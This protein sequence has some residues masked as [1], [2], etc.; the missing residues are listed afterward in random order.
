[1]PINPARIPVWDRG[2]VFG[3]SVYEVFRMYQGR[4]WLE[5]EHWRAEAKSRELDFRPHDLIRLMERAYE[6]IR[7]RDQGR[8]SSTSR[9]LAAS[10]TPVTSLSRAASV[11]PR[12]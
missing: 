7:K 9:S 5:A 3:D 6:T 11:C 8:N 12:R 2:F 10:R 1:M 4:C